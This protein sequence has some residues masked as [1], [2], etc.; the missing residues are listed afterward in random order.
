MEARPIGRPDEGADRH[1]QTG[2]AVADLLRDI[3]LEDEPVAEVERG[4][5]PQ[6]APAISSAAAQKTS[7]SIEAQTP[8]SRASSAVV[9]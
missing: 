6:F 7:T 4:G 9:P 3:G 1:P 8:R 5:L 2:R